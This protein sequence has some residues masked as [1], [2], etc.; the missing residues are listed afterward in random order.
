MT[1]HIDEARKAIDDRIA[2]LKDELERLEAAARRARR[3]VRRR[4]P[5]PPPHRAPRTTA[6]RREASIQAE[7]LVRINPGIFISELAKQMSIKQNYL[8]RV[9]PTLARRSKVRKPAKGGTR[10]KAL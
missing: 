1:E 10:S 7:K 4:A 9:M 6:R 8:Y 3:H 2:S 5:G